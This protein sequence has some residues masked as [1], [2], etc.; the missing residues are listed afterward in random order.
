MIDLLPVLVPTVAF[1]AILLA[2]T[3]LYWG[4]R[5]RKEADRKELGRRL[6]SIAPDADIL[7]QRREGSPS[8]LGALG[9]TLGRVQQQAGERRGV[10]GLLIRMAVLAALGVF[11]GA[12]LLDGLP[13]ALGLLAGA[14]PLLALRRQ[15]A[16]R[17]HLL[18]AQLPDA[19][20]LISRTLRAGHAFT[21]ALRISAVELP[22][23]IGEEFAHVSEQNRLGR[24]LRDC[25]EDMVIRNAGSFDV[26]LF[27]SAIL[28]QRETGG[29]LVEMLDSIAT[30]IRERLVF[31]DK[32][33][34]LTAEVRLS[35]GVLTALPFVV[36]AMILA[37]QP[38]YLA[39][40]WVTPM[41]R[42]MLYGG[43]ATLLLGVQLMRMLSRVEV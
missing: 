16:E 3:L 10:R 28:L 29:N 9:D 18:T 6:G 1:V 34:A 31:Q 39:P 41:G 21:D 40:L 2:S 11:V 13:A 35:A 38:G 43:V 26:R 33:R 37:F 27:A 25:L 30:T 8:A 12:L 5:T 20:D 22:A 4:R 19:L 42:T 14:V 7:R 15:A 32:V 24:E 17:S 23:P 36:A